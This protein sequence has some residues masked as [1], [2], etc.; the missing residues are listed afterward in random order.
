MT[1]ELKIV[2]L[3]TWR[4]S[5]TIR[6]ALYT[7]LQ[8]LQCLN[9]KDSLLH[10]D[11]VLLEKYIFVIRYTNKWHMKNT[12]S[13][14]PAK[15]E[16]GAFFIRTNHPLSNEKATHI[17]HID[18]TVGKPVQKYNKEKYVSNFLICCANNVVEKE[19][20]S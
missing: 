11:Y 14:F 19:L 7:F 1:L 9:L 8:F 18:H 12:N 5:I 6:I 13:K 4:V 17:D 10:H 15:T 16:M 20:K 2:V 3:H